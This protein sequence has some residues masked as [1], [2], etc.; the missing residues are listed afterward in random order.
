VNVNLFWMCVVIASGYH[1]FTLA[2]TESRAVD[3]V[4][5]PPA[6]GTPTTTRYWL[7]LLECEGG[8]F[9]AG[10]AIDVEQRFFQHVFGLGAKFTR[11]FPPVRVLAARRYASK[12]D[13]LRAEMALKALPRAAKP[14]FFRS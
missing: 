13:A 6:A 12:S 3:V 4:A 7:Y 9:Y 8:R 2:R 10:I 1:L 5:A 11:A 14:G